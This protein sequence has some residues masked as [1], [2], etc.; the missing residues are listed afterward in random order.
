M[1]HPN[2]YSGAK[3]RKNTDAAKQFWKINARKS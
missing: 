1:Y 2:S 3:I